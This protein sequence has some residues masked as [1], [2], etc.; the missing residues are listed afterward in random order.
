MGTGRV[1]EGL[2][3][4]STW[5]WNIGL[6]RTGSVNIFLSGEDWRGGAQ[7][8]IPSSHLFVLTGPKALSGPMERRKQWACYLV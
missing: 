2:Q 8:D 7:A 6:E 3:H 1:G 4:E 5:N